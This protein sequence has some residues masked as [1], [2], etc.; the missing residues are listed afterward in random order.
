[1]SIAN[2]L[3]AIVAREVRR[4]EMVIDGLMSVANGE[5]PR[6]VQGKLEGY[7]GAGD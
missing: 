3:K 4:R 5:N 6:I 7:L 2:K 1:M